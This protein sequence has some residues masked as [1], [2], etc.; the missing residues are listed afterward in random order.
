METYSLL[1]DL[2]AGNSPVMG[3]FP[4]QRP[5]TR[6]FDVFFDPR[7]NKPLSKH[8]GG[9][10]FEM[11]SS[12]LWRHCYGL[13]LSVFILPQILLMW[14]KLKVV[15]LDVIQCRCNAALYNIIFC[16]VSHWPRQNMKQSLH[17]KKA[18]LSHPHG[19]MTSSNG[20]IFRVTGPLCGE[21]TGD[22]WILHTKASDAELW[23]F[24]WSGPE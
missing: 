8:S 3:E 1:L 9:W 16:T 23:C 19:M 11:L 15:D 18:T 6:S 13:S 12:L 2:C 5:V 21:F 14:W 24:L 17:S 20:N 7:L 4:A 10:W 22:R